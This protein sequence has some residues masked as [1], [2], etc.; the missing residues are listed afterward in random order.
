MKFWLR[1]HSQVQ[2]PRTIKEGNQNHFIFCFACGSLLCSARAL[3]LYSN[4]HLQLTDFH[5]FL[6]SSDRF[7]QNERM[8][9][10]KKG[11]FDPKLREKEVITDTRFKSVQTDPKFKRVNRDRHKVQIDDRFSAMFTDP[12]FQVSG[13]AS[14]R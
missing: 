8:A 13:N 7:H 1:K 9:T 11:K 3:E 10:K 6:F 12:N 14:K 2:N 5:S 4:I